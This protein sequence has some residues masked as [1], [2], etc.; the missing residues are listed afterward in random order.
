MNRRYLDTNLDGIAA[1]NYDL[2]R[3]TDAD[4]DWL[5]ALRRAAYR[6]LFDTTWG[7]WDEARHQRHFAEFWAAGNISIVSVDGQPAGVLQLFEAEDVVE[8]GEIQV[9]PEC[10]NRGLGGRI[11]SDVVE[12][13]GKEGKRAALFLGIKNQGAFRLYQRLGFEETGRSDTHIFM[14]H[15]CPAFG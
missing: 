15:P 13:A 5:D 8:I 9:L 10:Q 7:Q 4:K 6:D 11:L 3:A 14:S 12:H 1:I 2:K